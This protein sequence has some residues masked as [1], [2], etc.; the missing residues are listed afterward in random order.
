MAIRR[1]LWLRLETTVT[2][3]TTETTRG[4]FPLLPLFPTGDFVV[5]GNNPRVVSV[6]T[7]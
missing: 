3:V 7:E 1:V 2:T 6:V 4:L 5:A